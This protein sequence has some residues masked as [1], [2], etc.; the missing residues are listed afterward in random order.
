MLPAIV[1]PEFGC[2]KDVVI[3]FPFLYMVYIWRGIFRYKAGQSS[4]SSI[5][6]Y[7]VRIQSSTRYGLWTKT[8]ICKPIGLYIPSANFNILILRTLMQVSDSIYLS[9]ACNRVAS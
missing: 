2:R 8:T 3:C 1:V 6:R 7:R 9:I 5:S 4:Q